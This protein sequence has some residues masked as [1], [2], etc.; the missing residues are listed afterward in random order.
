MMCVI[1]QASSGKK[2]MIGRRKRLESDASV[3]SLPA[4]LERVV[5]ICEN[6]LSA[7]ASSRPG[8]RASVDSTLSSGSDEA[9]LGANASATQNVDAAQMSGADGD[10]SCSSHESL[11]DGGDSQRM[12]GEHQKVLP[13]GGIDLQR[14]AMHQRTRA[15]SSD[16]AEQRNRT[17]LI[18]VGQSELTLISLDRKTVIFERHFKD[19]SFCSQVCFFIHVCLVVDFLW[20]CICFMFI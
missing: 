17:M 9:F 7:Q 1:I 12:H 18:Q 20:F 8:L 14:F 2:L 10:A 15:A 19:I 13:G 11:C 6:Q 16:A 4:D 5:S 3:Q